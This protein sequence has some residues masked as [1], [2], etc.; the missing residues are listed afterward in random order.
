MPRL[1]DAQ[2]P[3]LKPLLF[4]HPKNDINHQNISD[5]ST[6]PKTHGHNV[7]NDNPKAWSE[8]FQKTIYN[9]QPLL[10]HTPNPQHLPLIPRSTPPLGRIPG[11]ELTSQIHRYRLSSLHRC[12][13]LH[14]QQSISIPTRYISL[15]S[16]TSL[17]TLPH[18]LWRPLVLFR[19]SSVRGG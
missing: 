13:P 2:R 1:F 4:M 15:H 18:C 16:S 19:Q 8:H 7:A 3:Y 17:V 6:I 11:R 10:Q 9:N 12:I 5:G 14:L